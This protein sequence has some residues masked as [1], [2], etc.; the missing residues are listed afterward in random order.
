MKPVPARQV[1]QAGGW[2]DVQSFSVG[3]IASSQSFLNAVS[4]GFT[5]ML[6]Y[7]ITNAKQPTPGADDGE[8]VIKALPLKYLHPNLPNGCLHHR[9]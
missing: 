9:Q 3:Q 4:L 2:T 8:W 7:N 6:I 1:I 5:I